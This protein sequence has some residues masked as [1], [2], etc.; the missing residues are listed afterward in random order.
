MYFEKLLEDEKIGGRLS[1]EKDAEENFEI[2]EFNSCDAFFELQEKGCFG[3]TTLD[4]NVEHW[5]MG[6]CNE[7]EAFKQASVSAVD[8]FDLDAP[9]W[10]KRL[11]AEV[12]PMPSG[13]Y[14][15]EAWNEESLEREKKVSGKLFGE[16]DFVDVTVENEGIEVI[17]A[18]QN[19]DCG[20]VIDFFYMRPILLADFDNDGIADLLLKG[21]RRLQSETCLLGSGNSLGASLSIIV[22]KSTSSET[23]IVLKDLHAE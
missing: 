8:Y 2:V 7:I 22:K 10:W 1:C 15:Q 3:H 21:T 19:M 17:L 9:D 12:I 18:S 16:L 5:Y 20:E 23:P 13:I 6:V 11:P 14:T 4:M